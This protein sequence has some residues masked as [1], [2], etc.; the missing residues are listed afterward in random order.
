MRKLGMLGGM[1][2]AS[3]AIYYDHIN[4]GVRR[5][6]G[7]RHSAPLLIES[8]DFEPLAAM[9]A[10][11]DWDGIAAALIDSARRLEDAGVDG[12]I[13]CTNTMHKLY[14]RIA[15]EVEIPI[16]H[17][18]D[19]T[20]AAMKAAGV[21]RAA[22]LGTRFTMT[23]DFY[24]DRVKRHGVSLRVPGREDMAEVDRIIFDELTLG[25]VTIQSK[26]ALRTLIAHLAKAGAEAVVLG[27]TELVMVID[28]HANVLPIFDTTAIHAQAALLWILKDNQEQKPVDSQRPPAETY[29]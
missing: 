3:T 29:A 12:L 26:R 4:R 23:E 7:G 16:I 17:V 22:L 14:D 24:I 28:P 27:C 21:H 8:F 9:Q 18:A 13:L 10:A 2:W 15:V 19:E 20:A 5:A 1:S 6:L 25:E 11:D